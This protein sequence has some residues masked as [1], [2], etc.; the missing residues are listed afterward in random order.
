MPPVKTTTAKYDVNV[1]VEIILSVA[2][3]GGGGSTATVK[4]RRE[5]QLY[6]P[7]TGP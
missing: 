4:R 3:E 1:Y 7:F 5:S 6:N 2:A